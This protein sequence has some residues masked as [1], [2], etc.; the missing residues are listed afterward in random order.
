MGSVFGAVEAVFGVLGAS[1][2][3]HLYGVIRHVRPVA[4]TWR[5]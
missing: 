5:R 4:R 3:K 2:V 1:A